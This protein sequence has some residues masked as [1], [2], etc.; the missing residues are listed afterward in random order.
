M[1]KVFYVT[2]QLIIKKTWQEWEHDRN[3]N[4]LAVMKILS[5]S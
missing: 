1:D 3:Q 2:A 4:H 5:S